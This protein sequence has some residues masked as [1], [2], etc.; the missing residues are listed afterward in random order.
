MIIIITTHNN[1]LP[2]DHTVFLIQYIWPNNLTNCQTLPLKVF[3]QEIIRRS[4]TSFSCCLTALLYIFR[5]KKEI[6]LRIGALTECVKKKEPVLCGRRMFIASLILATK[7]LHDRSLANSIWSRLSG[8][9]VKEINENEIAFLSLINYHLYIPCPLFSWWSSLFIDS[10]RN[11]RAP[12][13][14]I[15]PPVSQVRPERKYS[16][17]SLSHRRDIKSKLDVDSLTPP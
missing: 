10:T 17:Y 15:S 16:P 4:R 12:V 14:P 7:Y 5:V 2:I 6:S 11:S 3:V 1:P 9:P 13:N 8:L